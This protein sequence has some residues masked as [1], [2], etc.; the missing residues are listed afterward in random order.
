MAA[1]HCGTGGPR[2]APDRAHGRVRRGTPEQTRGS[3]LPRGRAR[4]A[5][6]GRGQTQRRAAAAAAWWPGAAVPPPPGTLPIGSPAPAVQRQQAEGGCRGKGGEG[7]GGG[8][9]KR[10]LQPGRSDCST[11][12]AC[13]GARDKRQW[14]LAL[15][16]YTTGTCFSSPSSRAM[17]CRRRGQRQA[18]RS[19]QAPAMPAA[20]VVGRHPALRTAHWSGQPAGCSA[21]CARHAAGRA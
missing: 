10:E 4:P 13:A 3:S 8:V 11:G 14:H 20:V 21:C 5:A 9:R 17:L 7:G 15:P 6:S 1:V 2:P 19:S 12:G 18:A 16:R